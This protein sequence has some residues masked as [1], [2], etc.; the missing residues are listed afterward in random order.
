MNVSYS[1]TP[2][3]AFFINMKNVTREIWGQAHR[4]D[5]LPAYAQMRYPARW[6]GIGTEMG[7]SG[8][9]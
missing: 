8:S 6:D 1:L 3:L 7:F 9:F 5:L 4:S 2:N